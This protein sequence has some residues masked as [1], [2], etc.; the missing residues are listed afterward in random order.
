MRWWWALRDAAISSRGR[1][2]IKLIF[3]LS[4]LGFIYYQTW[5]YWSGYRQDAYALQS[6][7]LESPA[8]IGNFADAMLGL[9]A[10]FGSAV[11]V[12][13]L[14][15]TQ[16]I[17]DGAKT[18]TT[19][20]T[21]LLLLL[22]WAKGRQTDQEIDE[23]TPAERQVIDDLSNQVALLNEQV[24]SLAGQ[25]PPIHDAVTQ[26]IDRANRY[27]KVHA[28]LDSRLKAIEPPPPPPPK[29]EKEL[30]QEQ[31]AMLT[32][33]VQKLTRVNPTPASPT[34][35]ATATPPATVVTPSPDPAAAS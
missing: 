26:L 13:S 1:Y 15:V 7:P 22:G 11:V 14:V 27:A 25:L 6:L 20:F 2:V 28:Q 18:F 19:L 16:Y 34:P 3:W 32:A 17:L 33:Q 35:A 9:L 8:A 23:M 24:A 30:M 31:I 10:W 21:S 4:L 5:C 12:S 29:T